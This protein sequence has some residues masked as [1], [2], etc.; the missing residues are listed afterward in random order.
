[1]TLEEA[2]KLQQE[3]YKEWDILLIRGERIYGPYSGF[4]SDAGQFADEQIKL[5]PRF[6]DWEK[7]IKILND[8]TKIEYDLYCERN[9]LSLNGN[10]EDDLVESVGHF[11]AFKKDRQ[12]LEILKK[13]IKRIN[14]GV[15]I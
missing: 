2:R 10:V 11:L 1:M 9:P 3:Y 15:I 12:I 7:A 5:D 6:P 14:H 4:N 8:Q 13:E